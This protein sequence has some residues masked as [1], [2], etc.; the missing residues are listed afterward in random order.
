MF[1]REM[2][3]LKSGFQI[4]ANSHQENN[5]ILTLE[6]A[7]GTLEFEACEVASI[8]TIPEAPAIPAAPGV[9]AMV[10]QSTPEE[11]LRRA[12][13]AQATSSEFMD[14]VLSV[15]KI[16]SGMRQDAVSNKGAQGLMQLMPVTASALGVDARKAEQNALGG[17]AYLRDLL[18]RYHHNAVLALAAYNAGP[19]AVAKYGGVPPYIETERYIERVLNEYSRLERE[20]HSQ[21]Q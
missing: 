19:G 3:S 12:S 14:L 1:A 17:A 13:S 16:E 18:E 5:G 2:I 4:E 7:S 6:L 9:A 10:Q 20:R 15:A 11:I 21:K 8:E